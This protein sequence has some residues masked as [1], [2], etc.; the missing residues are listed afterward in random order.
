MREKY[1]CYFFDKFLPT[2]CWRCQL[3]RRLFQKLFAKKV[4][5]GCNIAFDSAGSGFGCQNLP[6]QTK[7][8]VS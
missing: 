1:A 5:S 4:Q 2:F 3:S 7:S 8:V 6:F